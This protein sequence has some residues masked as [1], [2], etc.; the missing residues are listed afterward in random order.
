M[1]RSHSIIIRNPEDLER[2]AAEFIAAMGNRRVVA[3]HGS[4]GA[5]KTTFI[6]ALC[7]NLGVAEDST[8]SPTFAILNEYRTTD[9]A[10]VYHFDLYRLESTEEALDAG[11]EDYLDSGDWCFIE[12]PQVAEPLLPSDTVIATITEQPG[13]IRTL[14]LSF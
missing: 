3:F 8:G 5:G 4:M 13:G 1:S 6:N 2:A 14:Q 9:D 7:R 10:P 11:I 12:W